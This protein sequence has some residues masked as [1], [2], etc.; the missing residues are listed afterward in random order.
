MRLH[1]HDERLFL[2]WLIATLLPVGLWHITCSYGYGVFCE[3]DP[4][5]VGLTLVPMTGFFFFRI[6]VVPNTRAFT[7]L[8]NLEYFAHVRSLDIVSLPANP[9]KAS[10]IHDNTV[11]KKYFKSYY[12][13]EVTRDDINSVEYFLSILGLGSAVIIFLLM[14]GEATKELE[15]YS[16]EKIVAITGTITLAYAHMWIPLFQARHRN[17]RVMN[18]LGIDAI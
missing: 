13:A 9:I 6:I 5:S 1:P 11:A 14:V 4:I 16:P 18:D 8:G 2:R 17:K 10:E 12:Y 7:L 15:T 3:H